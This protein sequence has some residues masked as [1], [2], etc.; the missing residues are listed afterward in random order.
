LAFTLNLALQ[1]KY[2]WITLWKFLP[3]SM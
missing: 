3:L 2:W 1:K